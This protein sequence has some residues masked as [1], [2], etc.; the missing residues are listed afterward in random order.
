MFVS[1]EITHR[2]VTIESHRSN[3]RVERLIGTIREGL[4]K[5]DSI[6]GMEEKT[7]K[8]IESYNKTYHTAIKCTPNEARDDNSG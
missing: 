6:L 1:N 8:I 7:E 4:V 3:G 2:K 5:N